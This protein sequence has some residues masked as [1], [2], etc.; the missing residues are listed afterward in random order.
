M[1][2]GVREDWTIHTFALEGRE[3]FMHTTS[4]HNGGYASVTVVVPTRNEAENVGPLL[5]RLDQVLA[6]RPSRVVFVD[7][8]TD[9]TPDR[10][11][12][13]AARASID[14]T[15]IHR[16]EG[17]RPGGLSGAVVRG[18]EAADTEWICVMDGD[19][20]HPPEVVPQL[21][22]AATAGNYE[23]VVATRYA[24]DGSAAG[25]SKLRELGSLAAT[26]LAKRSFP[27][28]LRDVSDPM[29]GFFVVR[30]K[31]IDLSLLQA[32]GFKILLEVA[33][34]H[35]G[36]RVGEVPFSFAPRVAGEPKASASVAAQ[37]LKQVVGLRRAS[38]TRPAFIYNIHNIIGVESRVVLP[39]LAS[40]EVRRL[41]RPADVLVSV[42]RL[43]DRSGHGVRFRQ[44]HIAY[45]EAPGWL[46]FAID[47]QR[48]DGLIH[49]GCSRLLALSPHVLYTNVVEPILRWR[50]VEL[51]YALVHA[52]CVDAGGR[53][54]AITAQT[55]T[56]K[57]T[58]MLK[59]L[60]DSDLEFVSD[61][62]TLVNRQGEVITYPKPL[63]ISAH[64]LHAVRR[65][66][67]SMVQRMC[68]QIQ[69]RLHS[70]SGRK[71]GFLL[72][73]LP[74]PVASMNAIVQRAIPPPKYRVQDLVPGV[75]EASG[76][77]LAGLFIIQ[78][79]GTGERALDP[80]EA[81]QTLLDNCEDAY[82]FPPYGDLE[83]FLRHR[84]TDLKAVEQKIIREAFSN[85][86]AMLLRSETLD[87]AERIQPLIEEFGRLTPEEGTID[88]RA[89]SPAARETI[90]AG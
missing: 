30:R 67:L 71:A 7:D 22:D 66:R 16:P 55:D 63:T 58:T 53:A 51:G 57:T 27:G 32:E 87:W 36:L 78:R 14:V 12:D 44:E 23:L 46:G 33:V 9:E 1:R 37:Y 50:F 42:G 70:K 8:S 6:G 54:Y 79:G 68:L 2:A 13:L 26:A 84:D 61:D 43:G 48:T 89:S 62:M 25:L 38:R 4:S 17:N 74:L 5:D 64:T 65:A 41:A 90:S 10:I 49:I 34:R 35:P 19:L 29:S 3:G 85:V 52:A 15:L 21:L 80:S 86:P 77:R 18:M 82:G 40:F 45:R 81:I 11:R 47:V 28:P 73:R 59:V 88:V 39:E 76:G 75:H 31:A 83:P 24:G 69:S 60:Q 20:Q 72:T 56:G